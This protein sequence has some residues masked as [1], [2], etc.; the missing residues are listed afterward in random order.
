[1]NPHFIE[2]RS[3]KTILQPRV[4]IFAG[5]LRKAIQEWN[6]GLGAYHAIVD[7]FARG[8]LVNQ[9]W[10]AYS[11]QAFRGDVGVS[12][13]KHGNRHYY[14]VDDLLVLRLKHVDNSY[15]SWNHPTSRARA[16][17][18]QASFPTIPP[19]AKLELGYRLD[20]TGTVVR[21]AV[22]MLNFK[23]R[24]VWRW[25]IWGPAIGEFAAAPRDVFGRMVHTH[26]DFSGVV[27]P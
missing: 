1:M 21:D 2:L 20:L 6:N 4:P 16:W 11:S 25:Q 22:V 17:D 15:R 23:G 19:M 26:D 14:I 13:D 27:L 9:F 8:V 24:S 5:S 3:A 18:A 7:E 12:L 10:Y